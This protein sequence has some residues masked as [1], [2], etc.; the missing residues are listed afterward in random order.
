LEFELQS[1][2]AFHAKCIRAQKEHEHSIARLHA[3]VTELTEALKRQ[4]AACRKAHA[5]ADAYATAN[6]QLEQALHAVRAHPPP[7]EPPASPQEQG[8]PQEQ[9]IRE[10]ASSLRG[11]LARVLQSIPSGKV[12]V[13]TPLFHATFDVEDARAMLDQQWGEDSFVL[14]VV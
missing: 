9:E 13:V 8:M 1:A 10:L 12:T 3:K 14:K 2:N 5:E 4:T 7:Q 6:K 11:V